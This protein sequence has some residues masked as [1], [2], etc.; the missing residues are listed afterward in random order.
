M[1]ELKRQSYIGGRW[2]SPAGSSF[3]SRDPRTGEAVAHYTSCGAREVEQALAAADEA[4]HNYRLLDKD[5]IARFLRVLAEEIEGLGE[6]LL[7]TAD[8]ETA[9]GIPRLTGERARTCGQ[10]RAFADLV[11][12]GQW[13]QASIDTAQPERQPLPRPDLR[14]MLRPIGPVAVFGASNFPFAFGALGGDTA[15]ALAAGNPVVV[16]GHSFHPATNELFAQAV[17]KSVRTCG[18]PP[19]VFSLLLGNGHELGAALVRHPLT[20][21]VGFTGSLKGGRT[22]MDLAAAREIP[23]PVYTEMGSINPVFICGDA[24]KTRADS[25]AAGLSASVCLGTGQFCTSPGVVVT[26]G[27]EAFAN[28]EKALRDSFAEKPRGVLL[29]E[30]IGNA[31]DEALSGLAGRGDVEWLNPAPHG[32]SANVLT[33]PNAVFKTSGAAFLGDA[34]LSEEMFGPATLVVVCEDADQMDAVARNLSGNLTATLHATGADD[35]AAGLLAILEQKAG[36]VIANGYPTG[37]EV[38]PSQQHGGPYPAASVAS[39]TSVGADAITR[40]ARFVAYQSVPDALLPDALK[41]GNPWGIYRKVNGKLT[42][43]PVA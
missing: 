35:R 41:N 22:F 18:V 12:E 38:V 26:L 6:I 14:R 28:F 23:I 27:G 39:S 33:P 9:L 3:S 42:R 5:V 34:A 24:L 15:S 10:L 13:I 30:R 40:F 11:G 43:D 21:A 29:H 2:V 17:E 20:R 37:V 19:G 8:R 16:K 4:Y 32:A 36:R 31:F 7:E 1:I 25:I